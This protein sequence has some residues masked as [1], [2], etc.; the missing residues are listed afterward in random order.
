MVPLGIRSIIHLTGTTPVSLVNLHDNQL[1]KKMSPLPGWCQVMDFMF[2]SGVQLKK[3]G[4]K[5]CQAAESDLESEGISS[6]CTSKHT[7]CRVGEPKERSLGFHVRHV[8]LL[9]VI[10]VPAV[11]LNDFEL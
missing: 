7:D 6:D 1:R 11:N 9:Q 5:Y 3:R 2:T 4:K 8:C 10:I